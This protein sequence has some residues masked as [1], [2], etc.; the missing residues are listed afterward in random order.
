MFSLEK[1]EEIVTDY[2]QNFLDDA[3]DLHRYNIRTY[4]ASGL[5]REEK[6]RNLLIIKIRLHHARKGHFAIFDEKLEKI[7]DWTVYHKGEVPD[8]AKL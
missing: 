5:P 1:L 8:L 2:Q 4:G 6:E 3:I 7:L